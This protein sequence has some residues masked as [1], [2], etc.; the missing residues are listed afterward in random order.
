MDILLV[1]M[2]LLH[3][4]FAFVWFGLGITDS[5]FIVP[6][7][8]RAG[9]S[10]MRFFKTLFTSTVYTRIY[11]IVAG[12]TTLMGILLYIFGNASSHFTSVGNMVLGIGALAGLV[13]TI[14]GGAVLGRATRV[15]GQTL[16]QLPDGQQASAD[17]LATLQTQAASLLSHSRLSLILMVVAL[18]GMGSARYL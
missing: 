6:T 10:G 14:H 4:V 1:V 3:I 16:A 9:E 7:A 5:V 13:A 12:M 17:I 15:F 11:A 2:R 18:V 8:I